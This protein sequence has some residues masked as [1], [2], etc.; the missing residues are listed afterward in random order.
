MY[1]YTSELRA[2][3]LGIDTVGLVFLVS[4]HDRS[5]CKGLLTSTGNFRKMGERKPFGEL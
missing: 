3:E 2:D 4:G 1:K 5:L